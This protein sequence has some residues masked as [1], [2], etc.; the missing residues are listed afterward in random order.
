MWI[1]YQSW[2]GNFRGSLSLDENIK[3]EVPETKN[4][5]HKTKQ[6]TPTCQKP[7]TCNNNNTPKNTHMQQQQQKH[8]NVTTTTIIKKKYL[9][10]GLSDRIPS[11][12]PGAE[13]PRD[14]RDSG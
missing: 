13:P 9:H 12:N 6:Y 7:H 14:A 1:L 5:H 3:P 2:A 4:S 11:T 10:L 8:M